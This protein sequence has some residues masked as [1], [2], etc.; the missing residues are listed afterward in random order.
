MK[1]VKADEG[2]SKYKDILLLNYIHALANED[3]E[4]RRY[5]QR[6]LQKAYT[7]LGF[8]DNAKKYDVHMCLES[9]K[10]VIN[11]RQVQSA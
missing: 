6:K 3:R 5:S 4:M 2:I 8:D 11:E 9:I 7:Q 10:H 1:K